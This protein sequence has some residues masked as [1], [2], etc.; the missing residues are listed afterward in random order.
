MK[1]PPRPR[2]PSSDLCS[3]SNHCFHTCV[4]ILQSRNHL[5]DLLLLQPTGANGGRGDWTQD[6]HV[7][8]R[9]SLQVKVAPAIRYRKLRRLSLTPLGFCVCSGYVAVFIAPSTWA[10]YFT[11]VLIGMAA[12]CECPERVKRF[13]V[14]TPD[15]KRRLSRFPLS[16][17]DGSRT[18][19]GG[20]L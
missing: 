15:G 6:L 8:K 18:V 20:Q 19:S 11:S 3:T 13:N 7:H 16:A 14:V 4:Y 12:A 2:Q 5:W 1:A 10:L 17:V 9:P